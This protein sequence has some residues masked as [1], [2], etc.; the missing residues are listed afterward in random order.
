MY[1][2][3]LIKALSYCGLV[4]ATAATPYVDIEDDETAEKVLATGYFATVCA[5]PKT[6]EV[7]EKEAD[8]HYG[9]KP[10]DEMN[11]S[12]LETFAAYKG[13]SLKG[14]K[15]KDAIISKLREELPADELEGNIEYGSPTIVELQNE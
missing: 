2:V 9:S 1:R 6:L 10:L 4:A 5:G 11:I 14:I 3:K 8:Y 13:V 7:T 15:K 12:E